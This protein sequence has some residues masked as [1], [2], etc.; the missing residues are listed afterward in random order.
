[1]ATVDQ[2]M[3]PT[4]LL[5]EY[6]RLT[7]CFP[8]GT[9]ANGRGGLEESTVGGTLVSS[10]MDIMVAVVQIMVRNVQSA[11]MSY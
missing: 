4:V 7:G 11:M 2:P 8:C 1:M 3:V 5:A 9:K 10:V 6:S